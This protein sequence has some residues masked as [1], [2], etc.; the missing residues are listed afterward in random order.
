LTAAEARELSV[1]IDGDVGSQ[2]NPG[3]ADPAGKVV[4]TAPATGTYTA[5]IYLAHQ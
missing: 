4:Y 2:I 1:R 5:Y 3:T